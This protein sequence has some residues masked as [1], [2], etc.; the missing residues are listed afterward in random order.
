MAKFF[1][2]LNFRYILGGKDD[3]ASAMK[4]STNLRS[5]ENLSNRYSG[6]LSAALKVTKFVADVR[7]EY[8]VA[9]IIFNLIKFGMSKSFTGE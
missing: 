9:L 5:F 3:A 1:I 7:H 2:H 8:C 6:T 4:S